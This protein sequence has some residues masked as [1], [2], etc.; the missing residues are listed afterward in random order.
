MVEWIHECTA[1]RDGCRVVLVEERC[2][3]SAVVVSPLTD[4]HCGPEV[5]EAPAASRSCHGPHQRARRRWLGATAS[6]RSPR[7]QENVHQLH[8]SCTVFT[9]R[10][11]RVLLCPLS[12][13]LA[14]RL[15]DKPAMA[16]ES[17]AVIRWRRRWVWR[18]Q[19][20][21]FSREFFGAVDGLSAMACAA[22][23]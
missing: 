10:R 5:A 8:S 7:R 11:F 22:A 21:K 3:R 14:D 23:C 18:R 16:S 12:R 20:V 4:L 6:N 19:A 2:D 13:L 15:V 9:G 17:V 1:P